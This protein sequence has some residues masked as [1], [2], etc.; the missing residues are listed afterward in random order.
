MNV[1]RDRFLDEPRDE[2]IERVAA[3]LAP[4][5][6]MDDRATAR[7]MAAVRSRRRPSRLKLVLAGMR[8]RSVSLASAGML[9]AAALVLGFI[10]R[11]AQTAL[12]SDSDELATT[13][14]GMHP[15]AVPAVAAADRKDMQ[16][17]PV[18]LVFEGG[19]AQSVS[20]VG[21]FNGWDATASPMQRYGTDGPWTATILVKPGRHVYAFLVDGTTLVADPRAP[22]ARDVDY[23][24]DASVLMVSVP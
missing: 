20:I 4:L 22:H 8:D 5:P 9:M 17:A 16:A 23:G 2:L 24:G 11:G 13:T 12:R 10:S 15:V 21:D 7:I 19:N 18:P 14:S 6:S 1:E 3:A